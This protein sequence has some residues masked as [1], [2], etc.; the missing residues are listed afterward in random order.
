MNILYL[1]YTGMTEPLGQSQ[2]LP[3][4]IG[5]TTKGYDFHIISF[6][7][8]TFYTKNKRLIQKICDEHEIVWHPQKYHKFPPV[9]SALQDY[10]QMRRI[11]RILNKQFE[12]SIVHCRSYLSAMTGLYLKRKY[13]IKLL[14]DMRGFWADER[15]DSGVWNMNN[16]IFRWIYRYFK[17]MEVRFVTEA[18]HITSL[19]AAGKSE[20]QSWKHPGTAPITVIPTSADFDLFDY[21]RIQLSDLESLRAELE[22]ADNEMVLSYLGS[23]GTW[24]MLDEMLL[25]FQEMKKQYPA[26]RFLFITTESPKMIFQRGKAINIDPDSIL[27][28]AATRKMVPLYLALSQLSIFFIR[29]YY[30]KKASAPTKL[31]EIMGMGLPLICNTGVGDVDVIV[32]ESASGILV[33]D[34]TPDSLKAI[35]QQIPELQK[36]PPEQIRTAGEK[37]FSLDH[38]IEQ[39]GQLYQALI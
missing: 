18:D 31:A 26:A 17:K 13:G 9:V 24:Y 29:P 33:S 8:K 1:S 39:Y 14:F 10:H 38:A 2:V 19:T 32:R 5:L 11:A 3:Y 28:R 27:V 12:F 25:F 36:I 37:I 7:K 22:L 30:S 6:E 34:F 4:I 15:K 23:I 21:Q 16:P 20:I 35:V